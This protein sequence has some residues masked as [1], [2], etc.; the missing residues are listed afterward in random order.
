MDALKFVIQDEETLLGT[1][2]KVIGVGGGGSNAVT[3]M[4][5]EGLTGV[6]FYVI[7][8]DGQALSA[9]TVQNKL[10][11]G[12]KVTHGLGAGSRARLSRRRGDPRFRH[13]R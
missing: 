9:S 2:I 10:M 5:S 3:R 12:A 6:E 11:I 4:M 7:N 8:T 1:K 13:H